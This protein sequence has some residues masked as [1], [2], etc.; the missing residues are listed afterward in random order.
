M[1]SEIEIVESEKEHKSRSFRAY[2]WKQFKKNKLAYYS[3]YILLGLIVIALLSPLISNDKPLYMSYKGESFFPAFTDLNPFSD[4]FIYEFT[5]EETGKVEKINLRVARWKHMEF[6]KVIWAPVT[7]SP[8]KSDIPNAHFVSP[9]GE[10]LFIG[11]QGR[12]EMPSKFRHYLGGNETGEDLL[13]GLIH[14]TKTSLSIGIISVGIASILGIILGALAGYFGDNKL[15]S[16]RGS[17]GT[18]VIGII[19][20]Y[21]Y[22]FMLRGFDLADGLTNSN[23]FS[24]ISISLFIFIITCVIFFYLGKLI[25]KIPFLNKKVYIPVDSIISRV[26]EIIISIPRLVLIISV[27]AIVEKPSIMNV[28]II[29]GLT[30]WTG[31]ARFTRAEFLRIRNLEY[32]QAAEALGYKQ[33]RIIFKHALPNGLAPAFVAIAFGIASAI[34]IE[35]G[36]SFLGVGV[37]PS[38]VTWGSMLAEG[39]QKFDAWWLVVF[40]GLAIFVTVTIFNLL[41]EGMRDALDPRLKS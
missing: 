3:L 5:N 27:A 28:M 36:L 39:R 22:A 30:T 38:A 34:L 16:T 26:I 37:P 25:G 20:A 35:S 15:Q 13:A 1:T 31:I 10:Q 14:G 8:G 18:M 9:S 24:E 23:F 29:I 40:P 6:D 4:K 32:V 11:K 19:V 41:G 17:F 2:A 33:Y 21:F 12:E 7:Y